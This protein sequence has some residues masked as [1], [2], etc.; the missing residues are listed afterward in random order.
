MRDTEH[1]KLDAILTRMHARLVDKAMTRAE[2]LSARFDD[3]SWSESE[4]PRD[5]DGKFASGAGGGSAL[6]GFKAYK[7]SLKSPKN[8]GSALAMVEYMAKAGTYGK[9]D[10]AKA[11]IGGYGIGESVAKH[12]VNHFTKKGYGIPVASN[13]P[14]KAPI[15]S[16]VKSV[17]IPEGYGMKGYGIPVAADPAIKAQVKPVNAGEAGK[18]VAKSLPAV[19]N[20]ATQK[21]MEQ[22]VENLDKLTPDN[23]AKVLEA[24]YKLH[25]VAE[26]GYKAEDVDKLSQVA[27]A[28]MSVNAINSVISSV[29]K[30]MGTPPKVYTPTTAAQKTAY[31]KFAKVPHYKQ[32]HTSY[33]ENASGAEHKAVL[34]TDTKK[35]PGDFYAKVSSAYSGNK[36]DGDTSAVGS[37]MNAYKD[38]MHSVFTQD[39]KHALD[40]YKDGGY[41]VM[42]QTMLGNDKYAT[43]NVHKAIAALNEAMK[44]SVVPADT[45]V[46]RGL[47]AS[48][49]DLTGF[50]NP[51]DAVGRCFEHTN[52]ASVSRKKGVS[53]AFGTKTMLKFTVPAGS[54]G[55]VL[56]NQIDGEQEIVLPARSVFRIDKVEGNMVHVTYLG[57]TSDE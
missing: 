10:I 13:P 45:P 55:I 42:N 21:E 9:E 28:G 56:G 44:K 7:A 15:P 29:K 23:S 33:F 36:H 16:E 34:R 24:I 35:I 46:Y 12:Y 50:D 52:F 43:E 5:P 8:K 49:K 2:E 39:E 37:A 6:H 1:Q 41:G 18:I 25:E 4:H 19:T 27:G 30:S 54:P 11:A 17:E 22:L 53:S 40:S 26:A 48:L 51:E 14:I 47:G 31:S 20:A 57:V 38:H 3:A 32:D